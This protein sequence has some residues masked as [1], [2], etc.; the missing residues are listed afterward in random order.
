MDITFGRYTDS[1]KPKEQIDFWE[2]SVSL[3]KEKKYFESLL[4]FTKYIENK[5]QDNLKA[6]QGDGFLK[7]EFTQGSKKV[8]VTADIKQITAE[9]VIAEFE[10]PGIPLMRRVLELNYLFYYSRFLFRDNSLILKFDSLME[11]CFP[12]KLYYALKELST[13]A[14][15][16]D[17]I[18]LDCLS[19]HPAQFF[20]YFLAFVKNFMQV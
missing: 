15:K 11:D 1:F 5:N 20:I 3:F 6:E 9:S 18:L 19:H 16:Q 10:K 2:N 17:D 8:Y 7:F 4:A 13:K 12:E 14:D